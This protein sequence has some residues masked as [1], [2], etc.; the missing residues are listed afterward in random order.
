MMTPISQI[1]IPPVSGVTSAAR[2]SPASF[3]STLDSA[4][5]ITHENVREAA[6]REAAAQLISSAMVLPILSSIRDST[7]LEG[8]PLEP[9]PAE[10]QFMPMLDQELADRIVRADGFTLDEVVM[11]GLMQTT[12]GMGGDA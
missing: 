3:A 1:T 4:M 2:P 10:R 8:G 7:F 11:K 6:A 5:A 9:S 12:P